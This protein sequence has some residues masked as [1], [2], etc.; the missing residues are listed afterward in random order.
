M[1]NKALI[2]QYMIIIF[3][4]YTDLKNSNKQD[5]DNNDLWKIFEYYSCIKLS[6]EYNKPFYEYDDIDPKFKELNKMSRN[7]T[8]IDCSDLVNTIVQCKL[9][10]NTLT[11]SQCSTFF[12]SQNIYSSELNKAIV[13]WEYLIITRNADSSLSENLLERKE[14]FIDRP[15]VK[16][17][18]IAF[19]ENLIINPPKYSIIN[20]DFKLR[21]YQIEA[22]NI[23][24]ENKN[25]IINLPTGTGKNSV[26]IYS[27]I[28]NLKYLILV[29]R[30][31]LMDQLKKEIIKHKPKL[32]NKIQ[33]IGDGNNTFDENKL[34]TICVFNS[35]HLITNFNTFEKIFIDE[36]HH[37]NKPAIYCENEEYYIDNLTDDNND[38]DEDSY[39]DESINSENSEDIDDS[40][41]ELINIKNYTKIIKN[42]V[43]YNNN[44]YLSATID[45]I[46]N[47]EYYSQDIRTMIELNYLCDYQIHVPIFNDDPSNKNICEHLLK[48]YRNIIIYC[49]T[50][51]EG[52]Q[53]NKLMNELQLN[54]S[55]Y[56]DCNTPKKLRNSIIEKYKKSEIPFLINVRIL[57]EGF[58]APITKGVCFLHLPTSKT[59][60]IQIIGR[61]LR[62][63]PTKNIANII[64]PFSSREDEKNICNFLKVIAQNDRSIKKSFENKKLG[65]YISIENMNEDEDIEN[66]DIEFKYNM[67]YNS[68]GILLNG[69][70]IW[71]KKLELVK[72]YID[73]NNKRPS[74]S[75]DN[76]KSLG[77]WISDQIKKYKIKKEIM[78]NE[79]IYNLWTE[80]IN[81]DKYKQFF[82]DNFTQWINKLN[83]VK[84]Y[85]DENNHR[86]YEKHNETKILGI[87]T[88]VQIRNYKNKKDIM[89]DEN[90][91]N[92][93][94]EFINDNKY[95]KNFEDNITQ[96]ITKLN[97]VKN[98]IDKNNKLPSIH[99]QN[100][101]IKSLGRWISTQHQKNYKNKKYIMK[102]ENIY[103]LWTE[104]INDDKYKHY[105]EDN[106]TKWINKLNE[107][108]TYINKNNKRPSC[109]D[110]NNK[111]KILSSWINT[112]Q[113]NY[114]TKQQIMENEKIY[115]LWI[116]FIND[117][118]YKK[119]FEDNIKLWMNKLNEVKNY[120]DK[121]NKR[122]SYSDKNN[123]I[124]I[125]G[126]WLSHQIHNYKNK[127]DIMKNEENYNLWTNFINDDK[128]IEYFEDNSVLWIEKLKVV[129]KYMDENNKRPSNFDKNN[130]IKI[131]GAW[132]SNQQKNYKN[133]KQIMKD[134][135]IYNLWTNFINDD[136]YKKYFEDNF[137]IW[138]EKLGTVKKYIDEN[139]KL[140][141]THDKNNEIKSLGS[142]INTQLYNYKNKIN[143]M[144]EEN[145]YNLWT[146]F[147]N[148]SKYKKYFE[149]N[150][151]LWI[152]KLNEVKKYIDENNKRPYEKH[153]ETKILGKWV[154]T[155]IQNHKNKKQIMGDENIYN[156]WTNFI[157]NN[158]YKEY[159][160]DN[161]IS[162][163]NKLNEIKKYIDENK[164]RPSTH[165]ENNEIKS[166][167]KW[168]SM[169]F[170][171]Y[172]NKIYIMKDENIYN[173]WTEFINDSKYKK[174][175]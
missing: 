141:S 123:E 14:L 99:D 100:N 142:W 11:W 102:D 168:L 104:F 158:K 47:F 146:E 18:L 37:I 98:Y 160:E 162:W 132:I 161:S 50:Q 68:M 170:H 57:V 134:E 42:L 138:I 6:E 53:I 33:L 8:G 152:N 103:N 83:E 59:T 88:S 69:E 2:K 90:I 76:N 46:D 108:K 55:K 175:F 128:Y 131:L 85:I 38:L 39:D 148:D 121:N 16:Q 22:I 51:K 24:K 125:L 113:Q 49:N 82:E 20:N 73:E 41:D 156:L 19:C 159:F 172:K 32:K 65:G 54:S 115:N 81:D 34:I 95:K 96:W 60:L 62:L 40:E 72:K 75:D 171:S 79:N 144:K 21:D 105:F 12:G 92:L 93:W 80:F 48:N 7:D 58:D 86:P 174:Y 140:P 165:A 136:K 70:E 130:E 155:Q 28:D 116:E 154:S 43:Q 45:S 101:E 109:S 15:Y 13:R 67:V 169:Q 129:K 91:Y 77:Y 150:T 153:N 145:I 124:N 27:M 114:K 133:K 163:I 23:V 173:L 112:Q 17:E 4:R 63:H 167:G 143:I 111:I 56:I 137:I 84:K 135:N 64:L 157:N 30:I 119:Y 166:L 149:D 3:E 87:W 127:E 5:F 71:I 52:K 94:T 139:N 164:K 26:I 66:E 44:I 120:I 97:E 1:N 61:C 122:P 110:E 9:R 118:K 36:A 126:R 89:K 106:F 74:T 147:I 78:K 31:I 117:N 10:K 35:V 107:V 29:P 25:V 151:T